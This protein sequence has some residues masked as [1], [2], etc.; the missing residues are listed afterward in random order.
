MEL[1]TPTT[2]YKRTLSFW[3]LQSFSTNNITELNLS[4]NINIKQKLFP[5]KSLPDYYKFNSV[6]ILEKSKKFWT[7]IEECE[8]QRINKQKKLFAKY[9][10]K[11][12]NSYNN[13]TLSRSQTPNSTLGNVNRPSP[14]PKCFGRNT[15]VIYF[16][17]K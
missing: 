10:N 4:K 15:H 3:K 8:L 13:L 9:A 14:L 11:M 16:L 17:S 7:Q 1:K 5:R 2:H 6:C 12:N